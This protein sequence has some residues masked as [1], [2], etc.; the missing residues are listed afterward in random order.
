MEKAEMTGYPSVDK[1]WLKYYTEAQ[2]NAPLPVGLTA[3]EY[4][5][6]QNKDNLNGPAITFLGKTITYQELFMLVEQVANS[7]LSIGVGKGDIVCIDFPTLPEEVYLLYAIDKI[8]AI[9]NYIIPNIPDGRLCDILNETECKTL[10][11]F[12]AFPNDVKYILRNTSVK[13]VVKVG[14]AEGFDKDNAETMTWGTF[15]EKGKSTRFHQDFQRDTRGL[16]FLAKTG[17]ST[18]NPKSVMI[19]DEGFNNI[20]H[21]FLHTSLPYERGDKWL[22]LWPIFSAAA[23]IC[24]SHVPLCAGMNL[25]LYPLINVEEVD[26]IFMGVKPNHFLMTPAIIDAMMNSQEV[27]GQNLNY[28]KSGGCGGVALTGPLEQKALSFFQMHNISAFLGGGYGMTENSSSATYRINAETAKM[29]GVGIPMLTTTIGIFSPGTCDELPYNTIGEVCIKSHNFML[30]Y[31][32]NK[33]LTDTVL[34]DHGNGDFWLHSGDLGYIDTDGIVY[35]VDRIKRVV[36]IYPQE[37]IFPVDIDNVVQSVEGV[38]MVVTVA[39]PDREHEGFFVPVCFLTIKEGY[40]KD[41]VLSKIQTICKNKL[42]HY[43][44]PQNL[45]VCD[46]IPLT[47]MGKPDVQRLENRAKEMLSMK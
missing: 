24:S 44:V 15:M 37:K 39:G 45:C 16:F 47:S 5:K 46:E 26:K 23:A 35:I 38:D 20:A 11:L 7:L 13:K 19:S 9:A 30:G 33:E 41:K 21:Q 25:V 43:S 10:F 40:S 12:S 18:G 3:Y 1:P 42:A 14:T 36:V 29:G 27:A 28:V 2:I 4:L 34:I 17:G 32:K 31:Y 6:Q 8:G 22:R